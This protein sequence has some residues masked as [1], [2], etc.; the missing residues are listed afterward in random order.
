MHI[1]QRVVVH[2]DH[3]VVAVTGRIN[4]SPANRGSGKQG[5]AQEP[6]VAPVIASDT[7][8]RLVAARAQGAEHFSVRENDQRGL[9]E[10]VGEAEV[11]PPLIPGPDFAVRSDHK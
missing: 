3:G 5:F 8:Q 6:C 4:P 7:V 10:A 9:A 11:H 2:C 1:E